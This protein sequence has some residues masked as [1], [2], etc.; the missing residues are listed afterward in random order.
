MVDPL[1]L[2]SN[3]YI[4]TVRCIDIEDNVCYMKVVDRVPCK[5]NERESD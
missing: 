1:V 3:Y 4:N 5:S 2:V